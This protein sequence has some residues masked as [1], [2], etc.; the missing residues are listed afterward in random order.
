MIDM[1]FQP[2]GKQSPGQ[3]EGAAPAWWIVFTRELV[4]LW[5]WGKALILI[6][7]FSLLLSV[8][9]Y[10]L[11]SNSELNLIPP[12]E[13]VFLTLQTSIAVGLFI[14][15]I[16]G[17]DTISGERERATLESLLLTPASRRQIVVGKFLAAASP[18]PAAMAITIPY[19]HV[20]AQ[21]DPVFG[22]GVL[23][24][25]ILG[26]LLIP[27]F[28]GFG[29]LVSLWSRSNKSSLTV[30]LVVY[31][32]FLL[33]TQFPGNAQTGTMGRF[34]KRI[35]PMESIN[36][37]LQKV[38]VN[39]RTID[40]M[41]SF[42]LAPVVFLLIVLGLLFLYAAPRLNL[43]GGASML[44]RLRW[45][46]LAQTILAASLLSLPALHSGLAEETAAQE[47]AA[48]AEALPLQIA[49][50]ME[51]K[52][53]KDGKSVYF[54]T[55]VT[56][57]GTE[58][59]PPLI[60]AMNIINVDSEG[61]VV[62]PEDWSPVRTQYI[63]ELAPGGTASHAWRIDP[64]IEGDYAAYIVVIPE[65]EGAEAT[66]HPIASPAI[67]LTVERFVRIN[68]GGVLPYAIGAPIVLLLGIGLVYRLRYRKT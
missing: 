39:N 49:V 18:W 52:V 24:G 63:D 28:A 15:L 62:D 1:P 43:D 35:N 53:I 8:M 36:Q 44:S 34:V 57:G 67:H 9:A 59:S 12:K 65:P 50:D 23:W 45:S 38:L 26:T 14:A 54:N 2:H 64:I 66:T 51:H 17:A 16:I 61:D 10:M 55:K 40:E 22:Q 41:Q 20:L 25:V 7:L 31:L 68:P 21:G 19:L 3:R 60:L 42:L 13:M 11:A 46:R 29:V 30:S 33:P 58:A 4:D 32:L 27:A 56:N 47:E 6:L 37:V 48:G 5:V